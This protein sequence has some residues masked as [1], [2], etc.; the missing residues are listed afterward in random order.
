M[1]VDV[2]NLLGNTFVTVSMNPGGTWYPT[3]AV[4]ATGT[5]TVASNFGK[6]TNVSGVRTYRISG[7]FSF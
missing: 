5:Y 6:V 4:V 3:D 2:F 1:F 7:R